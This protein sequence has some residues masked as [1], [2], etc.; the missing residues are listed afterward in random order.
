MNMYFA[1]DGKT[2]W[3]KA[4]PS[5]TRT[6]RCRGISIISMSGGQYP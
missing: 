3:G 1:E 2:R 5:A 6:I 4:A